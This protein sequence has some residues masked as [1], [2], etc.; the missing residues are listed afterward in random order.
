MS[1]NSSNMGIN[2]TTDPY[3]IALP[4]EI[5]QTWFHKFINNPWDGYLVTV[6][7]RHI[8]GSV[9]HQDSTDAR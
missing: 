8:P 2:R 6:M 1:I 7:F 4:E 9:Q 3:G 5:V